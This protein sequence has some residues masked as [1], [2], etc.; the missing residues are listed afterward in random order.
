MLY[1]LEW[2]ALDYEKAQVLTSTLTAS[3][4]PRRSRPPR[5]HRVGPRGLPSDGT[6]AGKR[7]AVAPPVC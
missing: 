3:R 7:G 2:L 6:G 4:K 5:L 1:C